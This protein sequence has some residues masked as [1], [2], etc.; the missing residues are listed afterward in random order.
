MSTGT[1][2]LVQESATQRA[3]LSSTLEQSGF[4]VF[5]A[6]GASDGVEA[7]RANRPGVVV[8]DIS[9]SDED[10]FAL[11]RSLRM[12]ESLKDIPVLLMTGLSDAED[13][14]GA[15]ECGAS[16]FLL[17]PFSDEELEARIEFVLSNPIPQF[18]STET[19]VQ[20]NFLEAEHSVQSS[21]EQSLSL[22]LTTFE[23]AAR[24][25]EQVSRETL[26]LKMRIHELE[27]QLGSDAPAEAV[28]TEPA[29][30]AG[31]CPWTLHLRNLPLP[32]QVHSS[33]G[34]AIFSN[35][36]WEEQ[37]GPMVL[38]G[39]DSSMEG[40]LVEGDDQKVFALSIRS[41]RW[42]DQEATVVYAIAQKVE[43]PVEISHNG[44]GRVELGE[45]LLNALAT[46]NRN[47]TRGIRK[48]LSIL[49]G[50]EPQIAQIENLVSQVESFDLF[51]LD[52]SALLM[53]SANV[54]LHTILT[55]ILETFPVRQEVAQRGLKMSMDCPVGLF[56][57]GDGRLLRLATVELLKNAIAA[58]QPGGPI[59]ARA[60]ADGNK[61]VISVRDAG[62]G[63]DVAIRD[64]VTTRFFTTWPGRIGLGLYL[65]RRV[66]EAHGGSLNF[67]HHSNGT[68]VVVEIPQA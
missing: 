8:S 3:H 1:V 34:I 44:Q 68:E 18:V 50:N 25:H 36:L 33:E 23:S 24:H 66:A 19:P 43:A 53:K 5:Q 27:R 46:H 55:D 9:L 7:A 2:L 49:V 54:D 20:F 38:A 37:L 15:L 14:I 29:A 63:I 26:E 45:E 51:A 52:S 57:N 13:V 67:I 35:S 17:K 58:S 59:R 47:L 31:E 40:S 42:E 48:G 6:S 11:C 64:Q 22:L 32:L 10:G 12:D 62:P 30:D 39:A 60:L 61:L 56:V 4:S 21:R 65:V 41:G 28:P 16:G